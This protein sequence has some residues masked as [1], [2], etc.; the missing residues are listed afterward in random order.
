MVGTPVDGG[1]QRRRPGRRPADG[2]LGR[3]PRV[4]AGDDDAHGRAEVVGAE[5]VG[6]R[7]WRPGCRRSRR[8]RRR[9]AATGRRSRSGPCRSTCRGRRSASGRRRACRSPRR[10]AGG[11]GAGRP[12][13]LELGTRRR[14]VGAGGVRAGDLDDD[15]VADVGRR[16]RVGR[17]GGAGDVGAVAAVGV[18]A[19]PLV[20]V[21]DRRGAG[22]GA[23][24]GGQRLAVARA[25]PRRSGRRCW[26]AASA[27]AVAVGAAAVGT[28]PPALVA[29]TTT[30]GRAPMSRGD[31]RV[32]RV[33]RR[34]G[35]RRS[36]RRRRRSAATG[37]CR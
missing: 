3:A 29:V 18:A 33:G 10:R 2:T 34:R 32:G 11:G 9:S 22:P 6:R 15:R 8:R 27:S 16:Q 30:A 28:L 26:P 12:P 17:A 25:C 23:G 13:T 19:L 21:G 31:E 14:G 36:S 20:G 4:V 37:R 7:R 1:R 35:C 5:R 24:I